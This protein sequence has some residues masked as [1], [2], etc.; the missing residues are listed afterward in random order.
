MNIEDVR[1]FCKTLAGTT[2]DI[3]WGQDLC[4]CVGAKMYCVTGLS[5]PL[6]LSFKVK[7]DEFDE[8]STASGFIPAPYVAR[9]KWVL[10]QEPSAVSDKKLKMYIQQSYELVKEKLPK[11]VLKEHGLL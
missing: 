11:K 5:G 1:A 3:K 6:Q 2:E 10:L 8:L 7:E 9:Y 4:F